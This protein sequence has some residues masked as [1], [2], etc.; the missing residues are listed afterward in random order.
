MWCF[1]VPPPHV[2]GT[3]S[4]SYSSVRASLW[5]C[6]LEPLT[7]HRIIFTLVISW[8]WLAHRIYISF[9]AVCTLGTLYACLHVNCKCVSLVR[10]TKPNC[11]SY[12]VHSI[13]RKSNSWE[14]AWVK[15]NSV[16]LHW[17]GHVFQS[18]SCARMDQGHRCISVSST[19]A[20]CI[21]LTCIIHTGNFPAPS[22]LVLPSLKAKLSRKNRARKFVHVEPQSHPSIESEYPQVAWQI[23]RGKGW[24]KMNNTLYTFTPR[25]KLLHFH[26]NVFMVQVDFLKS[27]Q[28]VQQREKA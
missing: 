27:K 25:Q 5:S 6:P 16:L 24:K 12:F 18:Y 7:K 22:S 9:L 14:K 17:E 11:N 20:V 26:R 2:A 21:V 10:R 1:S 13:V 19:R 4:S 15:A 28:T 3:A 23:A 8:M